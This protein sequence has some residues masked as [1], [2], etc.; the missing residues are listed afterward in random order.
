MASCFL[1]NFIKDVIALFIAKYSDVK[2]D[3]IQILNLSEEIKYQ[4]LGDFCVG[5]IL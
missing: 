5:S 3:I 1:G 2:D 4:K